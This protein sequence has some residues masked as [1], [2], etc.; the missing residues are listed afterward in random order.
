VDYLLAKFPSAGLNGAMH[1]VRFDE[2]RATV[3]VFHSAACGEESTKIIQL[4]T[5]H[6]IRAQEEERQKL[7]REI[8]HVAGGD[9]ML[10]LM[11]LQALK[12]SVPSRYAAK[13]IND[14]V[15][16]FKDVAKF[17]RDLSHSLYSP[18]LDLSGLVLA[19][20]SLCNDFKTRNGLDIKAD[21]ATELPP[22]DH[23]L[24]LCLYRVLEECLQNIV[25]HAGHCNVNVRLKSS[26]RKI[27][28]EVCDT[29]RG[30]ATTA[31]NTGMGLLI[32]KER[33]RSVRGHFK[34]CSRPGEGTH[35][36]V[37]IPIGNH[38]FKH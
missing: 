12:Q 21:I 27:G 1:V 29:G 36:C 38:C 3:P 19:S 15:E 14:L 8:H 35:I 13:Q 7:A 30:F 10:L 2:Q 37:T 20:K 9:V 22:L 34:I 26:H 6:L 11:S 16:R 23:E 17:L 25:K 33:V 4:L 32:I 31:Q 18:L 28:L 24:A 5:R